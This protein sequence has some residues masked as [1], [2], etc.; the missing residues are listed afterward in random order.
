MPPY[1]YTAEYTLPLR[2]AILPSLDRN[3]GRTFSDPMFIVKET[4]APN[5]NDNELAI[6]DL[7]RP[8]LSPIHSHNVKVLF[9]ISLRMYTK[10]ARSLEVQ[11]KV[12]FCLLASE[13]CFSFFQ[14]HFVRVA[15]SSTEFAFFITPFS[16]SLVGLRRILVHNTF[17]EF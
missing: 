11:S 2:G 13:F 10:I 4:A 1:F 15:N 8:A 3:V 17:C 7:R 16:R 12:Y 6:G 9:Q 5:D 14:P